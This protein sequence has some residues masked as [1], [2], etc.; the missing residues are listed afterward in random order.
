[1]GCLTR[2]RLIK[3]VIARKMKI[4]G[5]ASK[6]LK[7]LVVSSIFL[8]IFNSEVCRKAKPVLFIR[9]IEMSLQVI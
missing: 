5:C 7:L 9:V 3:S 2:L 6:I 1:M 8:N 4:E